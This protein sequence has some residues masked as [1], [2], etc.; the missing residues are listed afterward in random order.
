LRRKNSGIIP[1]IIA[2][3]IIILLVIVVVAYIENENAR[4]SQISDFKE[5]VAN[6]NY[7]LHMGSV[8]YSNVV[9]LEMSAFEERCTTLSTE[10]NFEII[11]QNTHTWLIFPQTKFS[12]VDTQTNTVYQ[13]VV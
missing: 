2:I 13:W 8:S 4:E 11:Q 10:A 7:P 6:H 3:V 9:T 5:F 1:L 12:V